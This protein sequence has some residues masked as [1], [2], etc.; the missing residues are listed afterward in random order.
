MA[1]DASVLGTSQL[2][3]LSQNANVYVFSS[4]LN[5][6]N[7]LTLFFLKFKKLDTLTLV[8]RY[9]FAIN[10]LLGSI[11]MVY[12]P[13]KSMSKSANMWEKFENN[14]RMNADTLNTAVSKFGGNWNALDDWLRSN[15]MHVKLLGF[16]VDKEMPGKV[17]GSLGSLIAAASVVFYRLSSDE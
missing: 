9:V 14:L 2:E 13:L 8:I 10:L 1:T 16:T 17:V 6:I 3:V 15:R 12:M 4:L 11:A 5:M 7:G